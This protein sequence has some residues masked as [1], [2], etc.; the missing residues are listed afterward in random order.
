VS[1]AVWTPPKAVSK[2]V[3]VV[4]AFSA[5]QQIQSFPVD[6]DMVAHG[7]HEIFGW[8]D[9]ISE[10]RAADIRGLYELGFSKRR[11]CQGRRIFSNTD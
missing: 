1:D 5:A 11:G 2:V 8:K 9:A 6:I 3:H 7:A 10:V 4:R